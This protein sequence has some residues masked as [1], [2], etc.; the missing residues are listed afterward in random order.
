MKTLVPLLLIALA[1]GC[2]RDRIEVHRVPKQ[3]EEPAMGM[4]AGLPPVPR[5]KGLVWETPK[6]WTELP[7]DGLREATLEP[8]GGKAQVTVIAL[9]GSVGGELANVNRW[10]GQL[11]LK[12]IGEKEIPSERRLLRSPAGEIRLY[13][14]TGGGTPATRL[15]AGAIMHRGTT[16]FFKLMGPAS[17]VAAARP[18]FLRMLRELKSDAR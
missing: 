16:W 8:P 14:F 7:A 5:A 6:G 18:A 1:A 4:A 13:D 9:P 11:S 12:P 17:A 2:R 10:R 3:D 15:V